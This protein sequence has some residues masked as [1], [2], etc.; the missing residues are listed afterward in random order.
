MPLLRTLSAISVAACGLWA[1]QSAH[2]QAAGADCGPPILPQLCVDFDA[3]RSV[4]PA[5]GPL[6]YRWQMGDSTTLTGLTVSHCYKRRARYQV[7]LEVLVPATGEVRPAEKNFTVD[8]LA[9]PVIYFSLPTTTVRVGQP[10]RF[11]ALDSGL[12][13]CQNVSYIW[14]FRDETTQQGQRVE[15][16]FRRAGRY[17]VRLSLRGYGPGDCASSHCATQEVVVV[18]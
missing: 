10:A 12:P 9:Q 17:Q 13:T 15:H 8:L 11:D 5:A 16:T 14:D 18:P 1:G 4:D 6:V 3:S 7:V 2:A